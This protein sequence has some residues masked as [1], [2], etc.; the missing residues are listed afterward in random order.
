M[1]G[2]SDS[3]NIFN[4]FMFICLFEIF[5]VSFTT[6]EE[7]KAFLSLTINIGLYGIDWRFCRIFG[8]DAYKNNNNFVNNKNFL[9][10]NNVFKILF[11]GF[12]NFNRGSSYGKDGFNFL[13]TCLN[14]IID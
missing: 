12:I 10:L 1:A 13:K 6:G 2:L 11:S 7:K 3:I 4:S 14:I 8:G 5:T 9:S